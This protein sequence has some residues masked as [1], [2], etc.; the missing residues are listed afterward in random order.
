MLRD[1]HPG[2]AILKMADE[3]NLG[4]AYRTR[5]GKP[6]TPGMVFDMLRD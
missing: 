4:V 6:W 3:L 1:D 2:Y 5:E